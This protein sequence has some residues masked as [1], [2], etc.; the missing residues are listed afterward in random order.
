VF[1]RPLSRALRGRTLAAPSASEGRFL[2]DA[3]R[4]E[5]VG[6]ALLLVS[7]VL[8]LVWANSPWSSQYAD[9]RH[10]HVGPLTLEH[11]ASDGG[12]AIFFFIAGVEL[13]RELTVGSLSRFSDA[14]VPVA[15]A[16]AGMLVPVGVYLAVN[17]GSSGDLGG[18]AVPMAT[19]IAFALAVLAVVGRSLPAAL[20]G[21]LLTLAVVDD[22]GAILVIAAVFTDQIHLLWVVAAAVAVTA[23]A[24]L[25][26]AR[27]PGWWIYAA[28]GVLAWWFVL[29]SG[30]HATI[31]GVALGLAT[32]VRPD[33]DERTSPAERVEHRLRPV[34]AGLAVP[35]FALMSAGVAVEGGWSIVTDPVALGIAGGLILG[36]AVGVFGG[37]WAVITL[38]RAELAPEVA[39][40]DVAAV[41]VLSGIGFTVSLLI[42]ELSF[43]GE[44]LAT[45]K[46]AVLAGSCIAGAVAAVLLRRRNRAHGS[47]LS[48]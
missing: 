8:A 15:A 16:L 25:Q 44:R 6:G 2:A 46:I 1:P 34:S 12:L 27:V 24:L 23:F 4:Q 38:T 33:K 11:W 42:A 30:V 32:R 39:W 10:L 26:R 7:A 19:D 22:L 31:A 29:E 47:R 43:D 45:A 13:K 28:L 37:A 36:K 40:R 20:R 48:A 3:L 18:W 14:L 9:L 41:S 35:F 21:F 5:T 17:L